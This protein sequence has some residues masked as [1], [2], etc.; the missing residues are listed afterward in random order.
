M[1]WTEKQIA[2]QLATQFFNRKHLVVVPNCNWTGHEADILAVTTDL[3]L[4]DV[5]IKIS[6]SDLKAD[7]KKEK[8][9]HRQFVEWESVGKN[10]KAKAKYE[11]TPLTHPPKVWKHYYLLP[12]E[13]WTE[14][15]ENYL[16]SKDSGI[17]FIDDWNDSGVPKIVLHKHA[18]PARDCYR[19]SSQQVIEIARLANIRMWNAYSEIE[20]LKKASH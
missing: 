2:Y 15:L 9:W 17:I 20:S 12:F 10:K 5:E 3:R 1:V 16:P 13:I 7:A 18:K 14:E 11:S 8:W 6:R 4:I 19:L